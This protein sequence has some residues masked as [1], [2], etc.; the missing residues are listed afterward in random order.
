[1]PV[2]RTF[3]RSG[4]VPGEPTR[5]NQTG[6]HLASHVTNGGAETM[7]QRGQTV[8]SIGRLIDSRDC[9]PRRAQQTVGGH[10]DGS[11]KIPT[12]V[13]DRSCF[14]FPPRS[15]GPC[16]L[17]HNHSVHQVFSNERVQK[18]SAL[19]KSS[20]LQLYNSTSLQM[21]S[22]SVRARRAQLDSPQGISY[23]F[24]TGLP[25]GLRYVSTNKSSHESP[26]TF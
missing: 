24:G 14:S 5:K 25:G 7:Q 8:Q 11:G 17:R 6:C 22:S 3:L 20:T 21:A 1:M 18:I 2:R 16:F 4:F 9:P 26:V 12:P 23:G 19:T 10:G 15:P 13:T